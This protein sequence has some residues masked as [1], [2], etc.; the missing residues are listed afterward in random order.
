M[1]FFIFHFWQYA[2]AS[3]HVVEHYSRWVSRVAR[4]E[5]DMRWLVL[6]PM[7]AIAVALLLLPTWLMLA[8]TISLT[9]PFV[10]I[11][12]AGLHSWLFT[13]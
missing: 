3:L 12:L 5:T 8:I 2:L 7:I 10:F 9:I 6:G 11:A 13:Q 4:N 1:E